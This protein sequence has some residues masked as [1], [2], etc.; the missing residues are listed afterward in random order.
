MLLLKLENV[1]V[2]SIFL[3]SKKRCITLP[4]TTLTSLQ[5]P[6]LP[7]V[8][9][10]FV[11]WSL[12]MMGCN[13]GDGWW[14]YHCLHQQFIC[15]ARCIVDVPMHHS[16]NTNLSSS[17]H[18]PYYKVDC[19][20]VIVTLDSVDSFLWRCLA[21]AA[22]DGGAVIIG[23]YARPISHD[24]T[25]MFSTPPKWPMGSVGCWEASYLVG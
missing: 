15:K 20:I 16:T 7:P 17:P 23:E 25:M 14:R 3:Y 10:N 11:L 1:I 13:H 12:K 24:P 2:F 6:P 19:D 5:K 8:T 4:P 22:M 21:T 18:R 9:T